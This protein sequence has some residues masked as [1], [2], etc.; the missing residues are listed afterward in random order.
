MTLTASAVFAVLAGLLPARVHAAAPTATLDMSVSTTSVTLGQTVA[1]KVSAKLPAGAALRLD[2]EKSTTDTF[3]IAK[4]DAGAVKEDGQGRVQDFQLEIIPLALG[5]LPIALVWNAEGPGGSQALEAPPL[6]LNVSPPPGIAPDK[7]SLIDI[8]EPRRARPALWPWLLAAA[9]GAAA[10]ELY[11]RRRPS[12]PGPA[13]AGPPPDNRPPDVIA[14]E[15]L[16]RLESSDLWERGEF[17]PFYLRLTEILRRY[18]EH[19]FGIPATRL[20]TAELYRHVRQ[21]ELD[22]PLAVLFKELFDRADLVKF[23]KV[24]PE[25]DWGGRDCAAA[26]RLVEQTT[27]KILAP[28]GAPEAGR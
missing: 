28:A 4:A 15:E 10:W 25:P 19:R 24:Q 16:S 27:P 6:I 11:R 2:L 7:P 21:A 1:M 13:A 8:K 23:A 20:T 3:A 17:K 22:R 26:R 12:G 14:L 9:L 5:S 18:L